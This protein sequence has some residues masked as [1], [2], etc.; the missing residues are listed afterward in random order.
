M[1]NLFETEEYNKFKDEL[2]AAQLVNNSDAE[3][4]PNYTIGEIFSAD[5]T[6]V[7]SDEFAQQHYL[8][9]LLEMDEVRE[10][11]AKELNVAP[12]ALENL[13]ADRLNQEK[14]DNFIKY[15]QEYSVQT[16]SPKSPPQNIP[17]QDQDFGLLGEQRMDRRDP[18]PPRELTPQEKLVISRGGDITT[19]YYRE[20]GDSIADRYREWVTGV[21]DLSAESHSA[22]K[23]IF[24]LVN[25]TKEQVYELIKN[26]DPEAEVFYVNPTNKAEG[27]LVRSPATNGKK[28]PWRATLGTGLFSSLDG[29]FRSFSENISG[30]FFT[31]TIEE[32]TRNISPELI[33][34]G[35]ATLGLRQL[36]KKGSA[37]LD[38]TLAEKGPEGIIDAMELQTVK[39]Q[40]IKGTG[41]YTAL[42]AAVG[43]PTALTRYVMLQYGKAS[44]V[45]P[46]LDS[47][48]MLE[49]A[50][51][52]GMMAALGTVGGDLLLRGVQNITRKFTGNNIPDEV[53][54]R[55]RV[56]IEQL[57]AKDAAPE[58]ALDMSKKEVDDVLREYA[59]NI[60]KEYS[61]NK[62]LGELSGDV[63]L[64]DMEAQLLGIVSKSDPSRLAVE[65]MLLERGSTLQ[66]FYEEMRNAAG[67]NGTLLPSYDQFKKHYATAAREAKE[68]EIVAKKTVVSEGSAV[69]VLEAPAP[70]SAITET[71]GEEI[72]DLTSTV[73]D[74]RAALFLQ[75]DSQFNEAR[76]QLSEILDSAEVISIQTK[77][78]DKFIGPII[79]RFISG[80]SEA[81]IKSIDEAEAAGILR[82]IM[83]MK[84]GQS[85]IKNLIEGQQRSETGTFLAKPSFTLRDLINAR[86]NIDSLAS[87]PNKALRKYAEEL[88]KGF[89][90]AINSL[91]AKNPELDARIFD[92]TK[93][94]ADVQEK[95]INGSYLLSLVKS[96][97]YP[98]MSKAMLGG[99][100]KNVR[101]LFDMLDVEDLKNSTPG[102]RTEEVRAAV[103]E[104]LR[105]EVLDPELS[106]SAQ[107][108]KFRQILKDREE[109][110]QQIFPEENIKALKTFET[111]SRR[112]EI[113]IQEAEARIAQL[114]KE[115][116]NNLN[117]D[118]YPIISQFLEADPKTL[119]E[120]GALDEMR[121]LS[122]IADKY[123]ELRNSM[124]AVFSDF[125]RNSFEQPNYG[126]SGFEK[127]ELMFEESAF[128]LEK[129]T[130][131]ISG[132]GGGAFGTNQLGNNLSLLLGKE[133]GQNYARNLRILAQELNTTRNRQSR[134]G[135]IDD[136]LRTNIE[137]EDQGFI[138]AIIRF[139]IPPLTKGGRRA[140]LAVSK[141]RD[142]T[143]RHLLE[144]LVD[145]VKT[146]ALIKLRN[147]ELTQRQ[148]IETIALIY[149]NP[150]ES[151]GENQDAYTIVTGRMKDADEEELQRILKPLTT[152]M[153]TG[154]SVSSALAQAEA[155]NKQ[156]R[157]GIS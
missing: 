146:D 117:E 6:G 134:R 2:L 14:Y 132:V 21:G 37:K 15:I 131:F 51:L 47:E 141:L 9:K 135:L 100:P 53:V 5:K 148:V 111:F 133:M 54:Q 153:A 156:L 93:N 95:V 61:E 149:S 26:E 108:K 88:K 49:D 103:L 89:N 60:G 87:S 125:L 38:K 63:L 28:V 58:K 64:Q 3:E 12:Y 70:V 39:G 67:K 19:T 8:T 86:I 85:I 20:R 147:R 44:G 155:R 122:A 129:L 36:L 29:T 97:S 33:G 126:R 119:T 80:G 56:R 90:D 17:R 101:K 42:G 77:Q 69:P 112:A 84:D 76:D 114:S 151:L 130:N 30:P 82:D 144:I 96:E 104:Q 145:P 154:G 113:T 71:V 32:I 102:F 123:P 16:V 22:I 124:Q 34:G 157:R 128:N 120:T 23:S 105:K 115:L 143:Q 106:V 7:D 45:H 73:A 55:I 150:S 98:E 142:N 1:A 107:N 48:T 99:T 136:N 92:A 121:K 66:N 40:I 59:Q 110:L 74:K 10:K 139:F 57:R 31:N 140:N 83:P 78:L 94:I 13:A 137:E 72:Y 68:A 127:G 25:P 18:I 152:N 4:N 41:K 138:N 62:T 116:R 52:I 35:V 65:R 75:R 79:K 43:I 46:N 24:S 50:G 27:V 91:V 109:Q 81:P 118:P 11:A